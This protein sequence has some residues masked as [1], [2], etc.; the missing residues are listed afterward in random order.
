MP[1]MSDRVRHLVGLENLL[2]KHPLYDKQVPVILGDHVTT[3][4]GTGAVHTAPGHGE[5]DFQVGRVYDLPVT[6]PV[7]ADG[8]YLDNVELFAGR[9]FYCGCQAEVGKALNIL[10]CLAINSSAPPGWLS[11]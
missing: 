2:L 6:N 11:A 10:D 3:E 7:G 9:R 8:R 1:K 4:T 5:E